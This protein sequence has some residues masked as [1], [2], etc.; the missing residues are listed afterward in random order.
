MGLFSSKKSKL[1]GLDFFDAVLEQADNNLAPGGYE[2]LW[3]ASLIGGSLGAEA[4]L[5]LD[6]KLA[7][8]WGNGS[9][10]KAAR[11]L[12]VW[13]S[14]VL[15]TLL[16]NEPNQDVVC[17]SI[18][19]GL[20]KVVFNSDEEMAYQELRVYQREQEEDNKVREQGGIPIYSYTLLYLRCLRALGK[21]LDL[22]K[23]PVPMPSVAG[24]LDAGL[25][26]PQNNPE[27]VPSIGV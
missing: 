5:K 3:R 27:E 24:L 14:T 12:E 7:S 19:T 2:D 9:L 6:S 21:D 13:T 25:L 10:I 15:L 23:I 22:S 11:L 8:L 4:M 16:Q 17:Q 26:D 1:S 20:A 18:A